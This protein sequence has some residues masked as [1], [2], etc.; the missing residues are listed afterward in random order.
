MP[1][2]VGRPRK[3]GR[4][5]GQGASLAGGSL[6]TFVGKMIKAHGPGIVASLAGTVINGLAEQGMKKIFK[7]NGKRRRK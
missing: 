1:N 4:P 5:K 6:G 3:V 7:G 2:H